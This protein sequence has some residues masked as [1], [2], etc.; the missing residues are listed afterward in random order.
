[1]K[2]KKEKKDE[3]EK[4]LDFMLEGEKLTPRQKQQLKVYE[5]KLKKIKRKRNGIK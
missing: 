4:F 2:T 3:F 5:I 1:M